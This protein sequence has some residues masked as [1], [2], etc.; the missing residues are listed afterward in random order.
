M[1]WDEIEQAVLDNF[2]GIR[3]GQKGSLE[4]EVKKEWRMLGDQE[5]IAFLKYAEEFI[6][7]AFPE[8]KKEESGFV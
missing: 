3:V 5:K 2:T 8:L 6:G 7:T 1:N 4:W